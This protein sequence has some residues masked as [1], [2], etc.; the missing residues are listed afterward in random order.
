MRKWI[1]EASYEQLLSHWRFAPV[2][3]PM[4]VGELGKYYKKVMFEK[5]D[6]LEVGQAARI[7][8]AIGW[9]P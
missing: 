1:D 4:F 7:S 3:D 5:R 6:K 8:K 2:G 9:E